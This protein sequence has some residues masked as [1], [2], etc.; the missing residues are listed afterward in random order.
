MINVVKCWLLKLAACAMQQKMIGEVLGS[1]PWVRQLAGV[2]KV[3]VRCLEAIMRKPGLS[4]GKVAILCGGPDW[5]VSVLAGI[6]KCSLFQMLLGTTPI[7]LF[8]APF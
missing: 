3:T 4:M 1:R 5:P 8:V 2:H 7:I 6:L